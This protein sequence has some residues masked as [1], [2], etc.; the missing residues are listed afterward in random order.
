MFKVM[1]DK[2]K[3]DSEPLGELR[4]LPKNWLNVTLRISGEGIANY[5]RHENLRLCPDCNFK[6][7]EKYKADGEVDKV[8][9]TDTLYDTLYDIVV[10]ILADQA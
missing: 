2:C 10:D 1:C 3:R 9:A 7:M 6:F 8:K 5:N 4:N